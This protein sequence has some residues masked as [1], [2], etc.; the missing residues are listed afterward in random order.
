V[1]FSYFNSEEGKYI[2]KKF[3]GMEKVY[4]DSVKIKSNDTG[5]LEKSSVVIVFRVPVSSEIFSLK[6][7][8]ITL[9]SHVFIFI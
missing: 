3:G 9:Y 4:V 5:T 8:C 2:V 7:K 6:K 1:I